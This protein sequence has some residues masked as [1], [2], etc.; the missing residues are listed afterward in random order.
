[1]TV[2]LP[3]HNGEEWLAPVIDAVLAQADGRSVE[4]IAVEDGS[5]DRSPEILA[6]YAAAG[7]LVIVAGPQRGAAAALNAGIRRATHPIVCQID[8]DVVLRPGWIA[9]LT[10]ALADPRVAAAQGYYET[11]RDASPWARAMGLDLESRYQRMLASGREVD[12]VCTGNSAYRMSALAEVGFF[13]ESLGYG[14]DN[15]ISYRLVDAGYRLLICPEARSVHHWRDG[16]RAYA[17]QQYGFGYGRLDLVAKHR[18]RMTGDDVSRLSMMLHAPLFAIAMLALAAAALLAL[19]GLSAVG[20]LIAALAILAVLA[21]ERF[22]VGARAALTFHDSAGW[23]FVPVHFTRD[24]AWTVALT[25]WIARR[26]GGIAGRPSH[27][28]QPRPVP[29]LALRGVG[30]TSPPPPLGGFRETREDEQGR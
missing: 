27:S 18:H 4:I 17:R 3:V 20:P 12:H 8:Q 19:V 16:W 22:I 29:P 23:W 24:L 2:V 7:Q 10:A 6:R 5:R 11:P 13:D 9:T 21:V 1:V 15:D 26:L 30:A 14:Y 28:M 25:V